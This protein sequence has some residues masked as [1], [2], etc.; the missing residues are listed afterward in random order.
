MID[1]IVIL[2][3][4]ST[5]KGGASQLA[6]NSAISFAERG[7][8]VVLISGDGANAQ[9][10]SR[11]VVHLGLGQERLLDNPLVGAVRGIYN[12][13]AAQMVER[14]VEQN[15]SPGT[16]Y[17]LHGWSQILSSS[18][19]RALR[20]VRGRLIMT[21]HDFFLTCPNGAQF[22]YVAAQPCHRRPLG[23][24]C[25]T[26]RCDRRNQAHKIWRTARQLVQ[27]HLL[28]DGELPPQLLI[29]RAMA[30]YFA[31]A[32]VDESNMFVLPNP[33]TAYCRERVAAESNREVLFVGRIESTKGID[34][35][36]QACRRAGLKLTAIGDGAML[37]QMRALYPE[38]DFVGRVPNDEIGAYARRARMLVMP[39]RHME[40]FGLSAVE[41]LWSGIPVL[42]SSHSLIAQDIAETGAGL[43]ID[44]SD[45]DALASA[46]KQLAASDELVRRMSIA[47]YSATRHLAL[48]PDAWI[49]A[50][51]SAYLALLDG[52][53]TALAAACN[54]WMRVASHSPK[55]SKNLATRSLVG[56]A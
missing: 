55:L 37:E 9:L 50:L 33:V 40:P 14:W 35:A 29:H 53:R 22:D 19:F 42:S 49:D 45:A 20:N 30:P 43:S 27:R 15:D 38:A 54:E 23:A 6:I 25:L 48:S 26:A 12:Q 11:G 41:A 52:Q 47:A 31:K 44:I 18:L 7:H 28:S 4:L 17:H 36:A 46:V 2:N 24:A 13:D 5:P 3:D 8:S 34:L 1:R 56:V 32:G 16:V 39:S 21:A 10:Q 51:I